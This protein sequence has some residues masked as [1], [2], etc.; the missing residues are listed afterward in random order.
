MNHLIDIWLFAC[1]G[2]G[3]F[4]AWWESRK[5]MQHRALMMAGAWLI[6][7][8]SLVLLMIKVSRNEQLLRSILERLP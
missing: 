2:M 5:G 1:G 8:A 4:F 3:V 7:L 6:V